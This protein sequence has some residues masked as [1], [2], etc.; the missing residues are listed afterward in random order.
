[1]DRSV[2]SAGHRESSG[3]QSSSSPVRMGQVQA[4]PHEECSDSSAGDVATSGGT[5]SSSP[6]RMGQVQAVHLVQPS[7]SSSGHREASKGKSVRP[8][9]LQ[10]QAQAVP[11]VDRS[12]SSAGHRETSGTQSSPSPV[13]MGQVQ[14]VPHEERSDSSTGHVATSGGTSSSSPA[15]MGQVQ[16]VHL[17]QPSVSSSGHTEASEVKSLLSAALQGQAQAVAHK[18]SHASGT[19]TTAKIVKV[20]FVLA[21][22]EATDE[23]PTGFGEWLTNFFNQMKQRNRYS[24][25]IGFICGPEGLF[26]GR[27]CEISDAWINKYRHNRWGFCAYRRPYHSQEWFE[28]AKQFEASMAMCNTLGIDALFIIGGQDLATNGGILAQYFKTKGSKTQVFIT[29]W[30][31]SLDRTA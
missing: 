7:V 6:A 22:K 23:T 18:E 2:S 9:A 21:C 20:A 10:G 8:A 29:P 19:T 25:M 15:R 14:A 24:T 27:Y 12:V 11:N 16:A 26:T 31:H 13:R 28:G 1:M 5:S 3:A 4:V 17:V 30:R